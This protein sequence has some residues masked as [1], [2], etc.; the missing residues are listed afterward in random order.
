MK[1]K[2]ITAKGSLTLMPSAVRVEEGI[3]DWEDD[4]KFPQPPEFILD[5]IKEKVKAQDFFASRTEEAFVPGLIIYDEEYGTPVLLIEKIPY[6]DVTD[7]GD[8][9]WP[10]D[11][12]P[13]W[14]AAV[15]GLADRVGIRNATNQE[16][17]IR[18]GCRLPLDPSAGILDLGLV[19]P[20]EEK[21]GEFKVLG[22]LTEEEMRGLQRMMTEV[23]ILGEAVSTWDG[24]IQIGKEKIPGYASQKKTIE[25]LRK[26][27]RLLKRRRS[28]SQP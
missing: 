14:R 13:L 10:G 26:K 2:G 15:G 23:F 17:I 6:S 1:N 27:E 28:Q 16:V 4:K 19:V 22:K 3:R 8:E 11:S 25:V 24:K 20:V 5:L 12:V 7:S 9:D 18:G 21:W